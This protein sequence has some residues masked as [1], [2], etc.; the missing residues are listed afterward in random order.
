MNFKPICNVKDS[1]LSLTIPFV[2]FRGKLTW[3]IVDNGHPEVTETLLPIMRKVV[4]KYEAVTK[5]LENTYYWDKPDAKEKPS[6]VGVLPSDPKYSVCPGVPCDIDWTLAWWDF[7]NGAAFN[8]MGQPGLGMIFMEHEFVLPRPGYKDFEI[9][10]QH[11]VG[12]C[13]GLGHI[14]G[15]YME[16]TGFVP[17]TY[18]I[19]QILI[20][21][22]QVTWGKPDTIP[23]DPCQVKLDKIRSVIEEL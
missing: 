5:R 17:P 10:F 16:G 21:M 6:A 18:E 20:D 4:K 9:V 14:P 12:H 7:P 11:E 13:F 8:S 22:L 3:A 15:T 2:E 23:P 19:P 1:E